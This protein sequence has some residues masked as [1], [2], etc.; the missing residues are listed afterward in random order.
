MSLTPEHARDLLEQ[1][2]AQ[3]GLHTVDEV[4]ADIA[5]NFAQVWS[6]ERSIAVF[7]INDTPSGR[8]AHIWLAAGDMDELISDMLPEFEQRARDSGVDHIGLSG[9][10]GWKRV[11]ASHGYE[12]HAVI[13]RKSL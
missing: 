9:R 6:G 4:L 11:L 2:C 10:K 3:S 7:K 5:Q 1:A 13:L 8:V 12:E